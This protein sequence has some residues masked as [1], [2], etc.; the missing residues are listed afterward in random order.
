[1]NDLWSFDLSYNE[2]GGAVPTFVL[3]SPDL[4]IFRLRGNQ[5]FTASGSTLL[6]WLSMMDPLW[7]DGC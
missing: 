7:N 6:D 5:C 1:M 2:L 4:G 3:F